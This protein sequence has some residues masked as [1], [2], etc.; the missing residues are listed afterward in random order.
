MRDDYLQRGFRDFTAY[1]IG[2]TNHSFKDARFRIWVKYIDTPLAWEYNFLRNQL[3]KPW[4]DAGT[5][6]WLDKQ[7]S[8]DIVNIEEIR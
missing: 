2:K 5:A 6:R 4:H 8:M 3:A 7:F 1:W